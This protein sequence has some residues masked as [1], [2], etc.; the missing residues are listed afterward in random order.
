VSKRDLSTVF[1]QGL[2]ATQLYD[3]AVGKVR[4]DRR[5]GGQAD[6]GWI[7][8]VEVL[9][10]A[11]GRIPVDIA[12]LAE[13][14]TG[15]VRIEGLSVREWVDVP[16]RSKPK[17]VVLDPG[18]RTHDWNMLNNRKR[19]G[20]I[21]ANLFRA[22]PG[23]ELYFHPY[24]STRSRRDRPTLGLQP[25]AWY[26]DAGGVTLGVRSQADYL[27]RFEQNQ[28]LIS[29]ATGWGADN[30]GQDV[31]FFFRMKNP[32]TLRAANTS[33]TLDGFWTEGRYGLR[34][35]LEWVRR[36]HLTFGPTWRRGVSLTWVGI[37]DV[38]YLDPGLY[39]DVGTV[40]LQSFGGVSTEKGNWQLAL[41][42]SVGGG[43]VYN[44]DGLAATGR[45]ELDP[46]YFRTSI[47]GTA[48]RPLGPRWNVAAR[49]F[50]GYSSGDDDETA[51]QRQIYLQGADPLQ[52]LHNPFLR[53]RGSLLVGEDFHYHSPGGA[54]VRGIDS[55]ISAGAI[56]ALN[57]ELD[58][59]LV[60]RPHARLFSRVALA[61]FTDMAYAGE[62]TQPLTGDRI[63][64]LGDAGLGL[65]ADHR[66]GDTRFTTRF[67]L[68]LYVSR[69]ELAQDREPGDDE[70]E[71]R[72]TFS[73]EPAF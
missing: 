11:P 19:V 33:Q 25:T 58:Q 54:G 27:G 32:V 71:L 59:T 63:G 60:S 47:E 52:Q 38:R 64:F 29:V 43:L 12:V 23:T 36:A 73:F 2:H 42:S 44:R 3:Y 49:L 65:R 9:R 7:T 37:D 67:D 61:A 41:Q 13:R 46:F 39:D 53:S 17:Q 50:L 31:D 22:P 26:N 34:A 72:W 18:V 24:F 62:A 66:I 55:R 16:T 56:V 57:L 10:R 20:G 8:R 51:K 40:E 28:A 4:A 14:D 21:L 69:P 15:I 6:G 1:G 70:V 48:R 68:P 45:P 5:T 30:G 35:S